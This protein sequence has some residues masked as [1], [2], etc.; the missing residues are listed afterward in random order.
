MIGTTISRYRVTALLGAGGMGVVYEA[1]D[2][3]LGRKVALKFLPEETAR[4]ADALERF[5]REARAASALNHP[6]ICTVHDFGTHEGRPY[7]VME[8]LSGRSLRQ[9]IGDQGMPL[10]R[11]LAYGEQIADALEAAHRAG[12]VHR[13]L[14]P[15]NLWIT[16]RDEAKVLDFGLAK[17]TSSEGSGSMPADA[18]TLADESLTEAGKTLGT[19][20]YMSPEQARGAAIDA[21]SDIFSLGVVLYEMATGRQ[22]F[23]GESV[24]DVIAA[25][26]RGEPVP[27]SQVRPDLPA[28]FDEIVLKALEKERALRH[29]SAAGLR[30]D[31]LRMERDAISSQPTSAG[32]A[33]AADAKPFAPV[34]RSRP[35]RRSL[36]FG[37][38]AAAAAAVVAGVIAFV[39][40]RAAGPAAAPARPLPVL[41]GDPANRTGDDAFD[42]TLIELLTTSL[43]QSRFLSIFPRTRAAHVLRLMQRDPAT[44]IDEVVGLEICQREGLGAL[45]SASIS[46]L[47]ETYLLLVRVTDAAGRELA[48]AREIF[49]DPAETPSRVDAAVR[50]LRAGIGESAASIRAS[51]PPLAEVSSA[52]L[53]AVKFYTLGLQHQRGG[54]PQQALVYFAKALEI[55]PEFAMAHN[56]VGIVHTNLQDM[57]RA[58]EHLARAGALTH[59]VG[60]AERHK[61]LAD[62]GMLRRD[63]DAAC[64]HLQVLTELRALDPI[65]LY[66]LGICHSFQLDFAAAIASTERALAMQSYPLGRAN[67]ARFQLGAGQAE[68]ALATAESLLR[69]Q[70]T[71]LQARFIAGRAELAL[72]RV[73][74]ARRTFELLAASGGEME[75][76][77]RLG[78]A[79]L[80][81]GTGRVERARRELEAA[82]QAA[83]RRK[84]ALALGRSAAAAAELALATGQR[85]ELERALARL[86]GIGHPV[87]LYLEARTYARAGRGSEARA[88][89]DELTA[90]TSD[91]SPDLALR[92]LLLAEIALAEGDPVEAVRQADAAWQLEP[93]VLARETQARAHAAGGR[94]VD[95]I[96]LFEDVL[97]RHTQRFDSYDALGFHRV[98]EARYRLAVLLDDAG[99]AARARPHLEGLLSLWEGADGSWPPLAD[100]RRRLAR[101]S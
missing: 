32:W 34:P 50:N 13:D 24:A 43:H 12:I 4:S 76:E 52:S 42:E 46:R 57:A 67:L 18:P 75:A 5:K 41:I 51:S 85:A 62:L 78:L 96:R 49:A 6:H 11:V 64:G 7:L 77:G 30:A 60:E 88:G 97:G 48:S 28:R 23:A 3:D 83:D 80:E 95:A 39:S 93:S 38:A 56:A 53:E 44:P 58:E 15:A 89:S 54:D 14:K 31:L 19:V 47:G 66:S 21:R 65:P 10:A 27:P 8:R 9:A 68:V 26:L 25:L 69:E 70:P 29:Q 72:G 86:R 94:R 101:P 61:I 2:V 22:P 16:E 45:V 100:V 36:R 81:L 91:S 79:D 20:A 71:N 74:A 73:E 99:D 98:V 1:E 92:A 35:A 63:Y 82:W 33:P 37:I 55:D 59:R 87:V 90:G 17:M 84:V 40:W